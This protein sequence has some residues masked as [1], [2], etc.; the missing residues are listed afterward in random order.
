MDTL[1]ESVPA[2]LA[3]MAFAEACA[4]ADQEPGT[5]FAF[6]R[7]LF[8]GKKEPCYTVLGI[9][10][11]EGAEALVALSAMGLSA[12]VPVTYAF[13]IRTRTVTIVA[14]WQ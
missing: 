11:E 13:H 8:K 7:V 14:E 5:E 2:P 4:L 6:V 1:P 12:E 10:S 3:Q 9:T